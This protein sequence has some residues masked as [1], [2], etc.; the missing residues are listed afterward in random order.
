[1]KEQTFS[2][3][4][5]TKTALELTMECIKAN[6]LE[7]MLFLG[8]M[9]ECFFIDY[10]ELYPEKMDEYRAMLHDFRNVVKHA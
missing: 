1:M 10:A 9:A 5:T 6:K 3:Q 7:Y 4:T 2:K 8:E